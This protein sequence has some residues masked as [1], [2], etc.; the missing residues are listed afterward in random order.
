MVFY[1]RASRFN[2]ELSGNRNIKMKESLARLSF[3]WGTGNCLRT[4]DELPSQHGIGG[5]D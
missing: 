2:L 3:Y 1:R 5:I 4:I